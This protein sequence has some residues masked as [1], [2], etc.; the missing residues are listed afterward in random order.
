MVIIQS[1]EEEQLSLSDIEET[2]L[3]TPPLPVVTSR[4]P[5][6]SH[7]DSDYKEVTESFTGEMT[8]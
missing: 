5:T 8:Q 1:V 7:E 2:F 4:S 3:V 6:P